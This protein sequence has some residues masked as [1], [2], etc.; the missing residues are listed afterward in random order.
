M[1][2]RMLGRGGKRLN[3]P[4]RWRH[5]S[6]ARHVGADLVLR[7][8]REPKP[9]TMNDTARVW[10]AVSGT[11]GLVPVGKVGVGRPKM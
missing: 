4:I 1:V 6:R 10:T 11:L 7:S 2:E 8:I 9:P 3:E 5:D